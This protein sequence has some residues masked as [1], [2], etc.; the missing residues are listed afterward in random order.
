MKKASLI[1]AISVAF[2]AILTLYNTFKWWKE[3][4]TE[5]RI[6]QILCSAA[7]LGLDYFFITL[8]RKQR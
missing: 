6:V 3:F 2:F 5:W 7:Y 1:A 8:Y 4:D